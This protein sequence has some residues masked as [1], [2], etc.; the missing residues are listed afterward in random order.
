MF[1]PRGS[2][3]WFFDQTD[4]ARAKQILGKN[5]SIQGNVPSSLL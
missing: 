5:C 1:F 2:V 3:N 4:M